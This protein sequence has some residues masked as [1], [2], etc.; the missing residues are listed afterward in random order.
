VITAADPL[1]RFLAGGGTVVLDGGLATEL[2]KA[3]F[4]LDHPLGCCRTGP[5]TIA[6]IRRA[7]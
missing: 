6:A 7:L 5:G 1:G 3:F 2:E 4:D